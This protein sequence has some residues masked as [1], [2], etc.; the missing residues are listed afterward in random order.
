MK[1]S[2]LELSQRPDLV[3]RAVDFFWK[4]WGDE[5]NFAFYK[6]CMAHSLNKEA[7]LPKFYL[8]LDEVDQIIGTYALLTNDLISRQDLMPWFACLFVVK[9]HRK[10]GIAAMLLDHGLKEAKN[11][12]FENLYLYTDLENFYERKAWKHICNGFTVSN[13]EVKIY[14]RKTT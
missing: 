13:L 9:G 12:G 4:C 5:N 11:K 3:D 8:A 10:K 7:L 2:I 6:D 14:T 1:P